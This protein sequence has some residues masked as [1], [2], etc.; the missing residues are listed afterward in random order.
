TSRGFLPWRLSDD[1]LGASRIIAS[2]RHPKPFT[3][4]DSLLRGP[5]VRFRRVQTW[6]A[7]DGAELGWI[8]PQVAALMVPDE[9]IVM[10][11]LDGLAER[12]RH[13]RRAK[14]GRHRPRSRSR[15]LS[16]F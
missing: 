13:R 7:G 5:H 15:R 12:E 16:A 6:S 4:P 10:L 3:N 11:Q 2:S 1:G 9:P 8:A 14:G